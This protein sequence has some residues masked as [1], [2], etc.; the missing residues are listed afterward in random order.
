VPHR[1]FRNLL[2]ATAAAL[3]VAACAA[4]ALNLPINAGLASV[5]DQGRWPQAAEVDDTI[6][7]L[8]FSGGGTRAAAFSHGVLTALDR[9]TIRTGAGPRPLTEAVDF[10]AGVSGGSVTAAYFGLKGRDG[11]ADFRSRFLERNAEEGID[12]TVSLGNVVKVLTAGGINADARLAGWLD[13]N[14]LEGATYADLFAR[15]KPI[16]WIGATDLYNRVPFVFEP[17]TFNAICSDLSK[18]RLS[19]AVAASAAV[20]GVFVPI[21][22]ENF[23]GS[24]G[25]HMPKFMERALSDRSAPAMLRASAQ[26]LAR[27]RDHPERLRY[28]KLLDGGLT[29]NFGVHG[30]AIMRTNRD[31]AYIPMTAEQA[32]RMRRMLFLVVDSG[33]GPGGAWTQSLASPGGLELAGA[34]TDAAIDSGSYKGYDYFRAM[35]AEWERDVRAWRCGLASAEVVRLRG[36]TAGWNCADV[37]FHVGRVSF[38]DAGPELKARLDQVPTRFRLP[39]ETVEMVIGA[40]ET[41]VRNNPTFR[42]FQRRSGRGAAAAL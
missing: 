2:L 23:G 36:T 41:A 9:E 30:L 15:K 29:D 8:A 13:Q 42:E 16:V 20:P 18:V 10:V 33:R 27:L 21:N 7:G 35:M 22:V 5:T 24:C 34:V 3:A 11:L 31:R 40:G 14:L 19:E 12:T 32:A 25:Y 37:V 26:A 28:V 1:A 39:P 38:D 17:L 6:V 4:D